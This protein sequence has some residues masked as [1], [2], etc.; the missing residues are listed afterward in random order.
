MRN[1]L[2]HKHS[3]QPQPPTPLMGDEEGVSH[4]LEHLYRWDL[5]QIRFWVGISTLGGSYFFQVGL[6]NSLYK[7]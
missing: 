4:F 7:K 6:E 5:G 2:E 3:L 1:I